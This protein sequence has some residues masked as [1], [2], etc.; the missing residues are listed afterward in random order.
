[1]R[2]AQID[3]FNLDSIPYPML[4]SVHGGPLAS[5]TDPDGRLVPETP[6]YRVRLTSTMPIDTSRMEH[7]HLRLEARAE[8]YAGRIWRVIAGTVIRETGF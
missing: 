8:S 2:V 4:S 3:A 1:M 6:I 5:R 7:A